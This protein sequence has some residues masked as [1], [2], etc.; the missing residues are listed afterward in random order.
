MKLEIGKQY[1]L[2]SDGQF[3][4]CFDVKGSKSISE[5]IPYT[6]LGEVVLNNREKRNIFITLTTFTQYAMFDVK[7]PE[8]YAKEVR[9]FSEILE[10]IEKLEQELGDLKKLI[11]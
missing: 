2:N 10:K 9:D 5:G 7:R 4:H 8:N 11:K 3:C 6:Y 1:Y